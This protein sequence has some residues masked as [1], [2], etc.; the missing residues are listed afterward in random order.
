MAKSE[1]LEAKDLIKKI[2]TRDLNKNRYSFRDIEGLRIIVSKAISSLEYRQIELNKTFMFAVIGQRYGL[3]DIFWV[4]VNSRFINNTSHL[5]VAK[6]LG[7]KVSEVKRIEK[8]VL[9]ELSRFKYRRQIVRIFGDEYA[10][11]EVYDELDRRYMEL[12]ESLDR[13]YSNERS[14]IAEIDKEKS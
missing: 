1:K 13:V 10:K 14:L 9:D 12:V 5:S 2:I 11:D 7:I 3:F 8:L 6:C 4:I